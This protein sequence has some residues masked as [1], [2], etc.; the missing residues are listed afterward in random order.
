MVQVFNAKNEIIM[1]FTVRHL[2]TASPNITQQSTDIE[3]H[4]SDPD[5]A[6]NP[7]IKKPEITGKALISLFVQEYN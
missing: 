7:N 2:S 6:S 5:L 3:I 1:P 4:F